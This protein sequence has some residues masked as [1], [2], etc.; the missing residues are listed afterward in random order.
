MGKV[1]FMGVFLVLGSAFGLVYLFVLLAE[2]QNLIGIVC[3]M[4]VTFVWA[5]GIMSEEL[6]VHKE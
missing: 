2:E 1:N 3:L 4:F 5:I 6:K